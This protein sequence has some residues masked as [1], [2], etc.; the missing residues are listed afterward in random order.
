MY[1]LILILTSIGDHSASFNTHEAEIDKQLQEALL[2]VD[3]DLLVDLRALNLKQSDKYNVFGRNA[4]LTCRN[5]LLCM[6]ADT[7]MLLI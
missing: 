2:M 1:S 6:N 3:P 4:N 7:T 5:I